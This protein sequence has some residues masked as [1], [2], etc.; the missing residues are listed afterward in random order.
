MNQEE[1]DTISKLGVYYADLESMQRKKY[2]MM[3]YLATFMLPVLVLLAI[4]A[5]VLW[6]SVAKPGFLDFVLRG[7]EFLSDNVVFYVAV[8]ILFYCI[9]LILIIQRVAKKSISITKAQLFQNG[10]DGKPLEG[11]TVRYRMMY[12]LARNT[13]DPDTFS[14][15]SLIGVTFA[16][17]IV[18]CFLRN[19]VDYKLLLCFTGF[20]LV[21][22]M[23]MVCYL[24]LGH[25]DMRPYAWYPMHDD[26]LICY[27]DM[28]L[29]MQKFQEYYQ[30]KLQMPLT[31]NRLAGI[32]V[33]RIAKLRHMKSKRE[34]E[35]YLASAPAWKL[36]E[37]LSL[38]RGED[39]DLILEPL[40]CI[41]YYGVDKMLFLD[42]ID[43]KFK[44]KIRESTDKLH[45][46]VKKAVLDYRKKIEPSL[47]DTSSAFL[48]Y[49]NSLTK[50]ELYE[51]IP[52]ISH[53]TINK[54]AI[55]NRYANFA[56]R[57]VISDAECT[58]NVQSGTTE[59]FL[60]NFTNTFGQ[61]HSKSLARTVKNLS[62]ISYADP[63]PYIQ[64]NFKKMLIFFMVT[65]GIMTFSIF[66][67]IYKSSYIL[68]F[69]VSII[70]IVSG[71]AFLSTMF[72]FG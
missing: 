69:I 13:A 50:E 21:F 20:V 33:D 31:Y 30:K 8:W 14:I 5:I 4:V 23:F 27:N 43:A 62:N 38:S 44:D 67:R 47:T 71:L 40:L 68:I 65:F 34:A 61:N 19:D 16:M 35:S 56:E 55:M 46:V 28:K 24:Y 64:N 18:F 57:L 54:K 63:S 6:I 59:S 72:I 66:D 22:M 9:A 36:V 32:L 52:W 39:S 53:Q 60:T 51:Y 70:G 25:Y 15:S 17:T 26:Y 48:T 37:Y 7:R 3:N 1:D 10:C 11:E 42:F 29:F 58:Y 41:N 12:E 2:G 49:Y 45:T